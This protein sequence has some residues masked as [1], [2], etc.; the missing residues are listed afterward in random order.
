MKIS[1]QG[2]F[3]SASAALLKEN[4]DFKVYDPTTREEKG[5]KIIEQV[6]IPKYDQVKEIPLISF[7]YFDVESGK[8][9]SVKRG[10]FPITV[11][12]LEK[13]E[14]LKVVGG[15]LPPVSVLPKE[16]LG[17]DIIFIKEYPGLLIK[18]DE[19]FYRSPVFMVIFIFTFSLWLG[20]WMNYQ[21]T[22][23]LK[24]D[25]VYARRLQAPHKAKSGLAQAKKLLAKEDPAAFYDVLFKTLQEY[26]GDKFHL[27]SGAITFLAIENIL[28]EKGQRETIGE[29]LKS[30]FDECDMV[31][32]ATVKMD[33]GKMENSYRT[34]EKI[35]DYLERNI[36]L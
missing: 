6:V 32:F 16:E 31:R 3:K 17:R 12:K 8:Y 11:K 4:K 36:R 28:K 23:R 27:S 26:L 25:I 18:R 24:S 22:H 29:D 21:K 10:P 1:G 7:S 13:E 2:N 19:F 14:E 5:E 33:K 20:L 15:S 35:I 34:L 30:I 9:V